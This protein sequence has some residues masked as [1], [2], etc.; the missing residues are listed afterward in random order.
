MA[1]KERPTSGVQEAR[2]SDLPPPHQEGGGSPFYPEK[3]DGEFFRSNRQEPYR[4]VEIDLRKP[5]DL[6]G[7]PE[8]VWFPMPNNEFCA[9][10]GTT[11]TTLILPSGRV[12]KEEFSIVYIDRD[13]EGIYQITADSL[14]WLKLDAAKRRLDREVA[15]MTED[16]GELE[17]LKEQH[18]TVFNWLS[19]FDHNS[20]MRSAIGSETADFRFTFGFAVT[21][22]TDLGISYRYKAELSRSKERRARETKIM[23]N[24]VGM[25]GLRLPPLPH[26]PACGS[27]PGGSSKTR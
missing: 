2:G 20:R 12:I 18:R 14:G 16:G 10:Q 27:A 8:V 4:E 17:M 24:R 5:L 3:P 25:A 21:M 23:Q 1:C 13:S 7:I 9:I 15:L 11:D 26:H 19:R 6:S 22:N